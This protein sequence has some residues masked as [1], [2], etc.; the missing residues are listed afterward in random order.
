MMK[1]DELRFSFEIAWDDRWYRWQTLLTLAILLLGSGHVLWKLV[2]EGI[3]N[4]LLVFHYNQ[5]LG[6]DE[7]QRWGWIFAFVGIIALVVFID[8]TASFQ[9]FRHDK[10]ASRVLLM[11]A[12]LFATLMFAAAFFITSVNV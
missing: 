5:Y 4:G 8:L 12:T 3:E 9:L 7:V 1:L 10:I 6:I 2:P 11:T